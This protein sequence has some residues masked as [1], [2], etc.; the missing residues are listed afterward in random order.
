MLDGAIKELA[1]GSAEPGPNMLELA[2]RGAFFLAGH[3]VLTVTS[4]VGEYAEEGLSTNDHRS[5]ATLL[6]LA[7]R[8][9]FGL[10]VLHRAIVD[11]RAGRLPS[12]IDEAGAVLHGE[13]ISPRWLRENLQP[14]VPNLVTPEQD[15]AHRLL[16]WEAKIADLHDAVSAVSNGAMLPRSRSWCA[17]RE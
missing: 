7:L 12:A 2:A 5:P 14:E 3:R 13:E 17:S 8:S 11:G 15:L 10:R 6:G 16:D 1:E 4:T 9:E